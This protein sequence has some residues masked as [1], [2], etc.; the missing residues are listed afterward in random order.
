MI[1]GYVSSALLLSTSRGSQL[2]FVTLGL[3][4]LIPM[5]IDGFRQVLTSYWSTTPVR[6]VTGWLAGMGQILLLAGMTRGV[7]PLLR[8]FGSFL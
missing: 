2:P 4:L 3:L 5:G 8:S 6:V 7:V 1:L